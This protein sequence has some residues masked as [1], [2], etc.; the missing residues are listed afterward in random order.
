VHKK[1]CRVAIF[2]EKSEVVDGLMFRSSVVGSEV[3]MARLEASRE[4]VLVAVEFYC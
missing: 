2:D 3:F 1:V 4:K